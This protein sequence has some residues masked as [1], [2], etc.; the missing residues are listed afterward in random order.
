MLRQLQPRLYSIS[1]SPLEFCPGNTAVEATIAV[2]RYSSLGK[3]RQGICS[4]QVWLGPAP[5][6]ITVDTPC[7]CL[8]DV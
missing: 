7:W 2:V 3:Q 8:N 5:A 6:S 4:T 1:S